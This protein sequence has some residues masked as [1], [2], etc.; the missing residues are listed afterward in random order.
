MEVWKKVKG[1]DKVKCTGMLHSVNILKK[2]KK[3]KVKATSKMNQ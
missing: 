2:N 1:M 3:V